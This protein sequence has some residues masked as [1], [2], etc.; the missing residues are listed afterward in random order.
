VEQEGP[1]APPRTLMVQPTSPTDLIARQ[2][3]D[4]DR[5]AVFSESMAVAQT[6]AKSVLG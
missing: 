6:L 1:P 5:D 4:R 3:S 2:L